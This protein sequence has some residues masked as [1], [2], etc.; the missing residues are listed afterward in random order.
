MP[1]E[2]ESGNLQ[3]TEEEITLYKPAA[4]LVARSIREYIDLRQPM[5]RSQFTVLYFAYAVVTSDEELMLD[6]VA[7]VEAEIEK[8]KRPN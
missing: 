7:V 6:I 8:R 5:T 3:L 1:I 4:E 2:L